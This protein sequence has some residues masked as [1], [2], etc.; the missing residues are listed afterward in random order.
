MFKVD[1]AIFGGVEKLNHG[2][3]SPLTCANPNRKYP[4]K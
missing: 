2:P 4:K 1:L 3:D